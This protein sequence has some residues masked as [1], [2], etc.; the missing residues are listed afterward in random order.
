M[1]V[2]FFKPTVVIKVSNYNLKKKKKKT[3]GK[4]GLSVLFSCHS[5][6]LGILSQAQLPAPVVCIPEISENALLCLQYRCGGVFETLQA[7]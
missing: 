2:T 7:F 6:G 4:C 3:S 1:T 5:Y